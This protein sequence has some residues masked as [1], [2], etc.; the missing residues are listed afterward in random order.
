MNTG[1]AGQ[2]ALVT[3]AGHPRGIGR[4][5]CRRLAQQGAIVI[6]SDIG[7]DA[8]DG[9][10]TQLG[11]NV[12]A[13]ALDVTQPDNWQ[14]VVSA[15]IE[16]YGKL[17]ILV[18]NAGV[19]LGSSDFLGLS[20]KDWDLTLAVNVRGVAN[21]CQAV[22]PHM[23]ERQSGRI[24]NMASL[25]GIGA[26]EAIPACYTASKFAVTGLTKQLAANYAA[27]G[28]RVNAVCPGSIVTQ[29][30]DST[31]QLIADANNVS[32]EQAAKIEAESIPLGYSAQPEAIGDAVVYLV[33]DQAAYVTGIALPVA[34]GMSPGL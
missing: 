18:N 14:S 4:A 22:I 8:A 2:V 11:D 33:S 19:G 30:Y 27:S 32:L 15:I 6:A 20:E 10:L 1:L 3:G 26:I 9:E 24:V 7:M 28:I 13:A 34:G 5:I 29:M 17:D 31:L 16:K 12:S 23:L 21:G 25:A